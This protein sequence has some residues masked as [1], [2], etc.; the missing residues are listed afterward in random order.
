VPDVIVAS[1]PTIEICAQVS[2]FCAKHRIPLLIDIRDQ[3]PDL[4][5]ENQSGLKSEVIRLLS[6]GMRRLARKA[7]S[8]ADAITANGPDVVHWGLNYA[9]RTKKSIDRALFMSYEKPELSEE[10]ITKALE[11]LV[12]KGVQFDRPIVTYT[13]MIGQTIDLDPVIEAAEKVGD[14]AWIVIGGAGDELEEWSDRAKHCS[15]ILFTKWLTSDEVAVLLSRSII[16]LIPYRQAANFE[17]GITNKPVEYLANG[18]TVLTSLRRGTLV[19]LISEYHAGSTYTSGAELA[20]QILATVAQPNSD[21]SL[22]LFNEKFHPDQ[23]YGE[24]IELI[25]TVVSASGTHDRD[26][27]SQEDPH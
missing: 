8:G 12:A 27:T 16:G 1:Y 22:K 4:Y 17:R 20:D 13:G 24:W 23:V 10:R 19:D 6:F 9:G 15:N 26:A 3:Y 2:E 14:Q 7:L 5:W 11:M 25:E 21:P 18:L